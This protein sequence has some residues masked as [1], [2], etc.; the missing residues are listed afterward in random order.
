[1]KFD[2]R[3]LAFYTPLYPSF[4]SSAYYPL[5]HTK[6]Q[7]F[8]LVFL[9]HFVLWFCDFFIM[10]LF[11]WVLGW[12][13]FLRFVLPGVLVPRSSI[14]GAL[15]R[16]PTQSG[17]LWFTQYFLS[18]FVLCRFGWTSFFL[19]PQFSFC[20]HC[21]LWFL[22][23]YRFPPS[24]SRVGSRVG[25][26]GF[27]CFLKGSASSR[28]G[29]T[30][31]LRCGLFLCRSSIILRSFP[32]ACLLQ[33]SPH[34]DLHLL[35]AFSFRR[36]SPSELPFCW[37]LGQGFFFSVS[38]FSVSLLPSR[39]CFFYRSRILTFDGF[40]LYLIPRNV[41]SS[42]PSVSSLAFLL[43]IPSLM[44][45]GM[46]PIPPLNPSPLRESSLAWFFFRTPPDPPC[47]VTAPSIARLPQP[48][49]LHR[50]SA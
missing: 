11:P 41:L 7:C 25:L 28:S 20:H 1:V 19:P 8:S 5:Q 18:P 15:N 22:V 45:L 10:V 29:C 3:H 23:F 46:H 35:Y 21:G 39:F 49:V 4:Q 14:L 27:F 12:F 44:F 30:L 17:T 47:H 9:R 26:F 32:G 34:V 33:S 16:P 31:A 43:C 38:F 2:I 36:D 24:K 6:S 42:A 37:F 13:F 50:P 48:P 40:F